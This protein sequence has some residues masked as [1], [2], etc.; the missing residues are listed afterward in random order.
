[1][2][3]RQQLFSIALCWLAVKDSAARK[4]MPDAPAGAFWAA[5]FGG[6]CV[7]VDR[8][9]DLVIVLRW[10]PEFEQVLAAFLGALER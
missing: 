9:H 7:Y 1:M 10:L 8:E 3:P 6:N 4:A 5:G 2:K